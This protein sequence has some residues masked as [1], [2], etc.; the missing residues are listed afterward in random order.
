MRFVYFLFLHTL[1][2]STAATAQNARTTATASR[3]IARSYAYWNAALNAYEYDDSAR[4]FYSGSQT[5][6]GG[7]NEL[8]ACDSVH[9]FS[10]SGTTVNSTSRFYQSFDAAGNIVQL[11]HQLPDGSGGYRLYER[12]LYTY[13]AT[14]HLLSSTKDAYDVPTSSWE[15]QYRMLYTRSAAGSVT[16]ETNE[17]WN[18]AT[19]AWEPDHRYT[20]TF[21]AS[22]ALTGRSYENWVGGAWQPV[23]R[24]TYT[25][26]AAGLPETMISEGYVAA[27]SS[28]I[29]YNREL[30]TFNADGKQTERYWQYWST[31]EA[32]WKNN[33]RTLTTYSGTLPTEETRAYWYGTATTGTWEPSA[34]NT[35]THDAAG[36]QLTSTDHDWNAGTSSYDPR[37]QNKRTY[38]SYNQETE[39]VGLYWDAALGGFY[40]G[41]SSTS[42]ARKY[43]ETYTG[44]REDL[45]AAGP[46]FRVYPVP[47]VAVMNVMLEET[48]AADAVVTLLSGDGRVLQQ[49]ALQG[50]RAILLVD[51]LPAGSYVVRLSADGSVQSRV[52]TISGDAR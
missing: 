27:T 41:P 51:G 31:P 46:A 12:E 25:I 8:P 52:V 20:Y 28:W 44:L 6:A 14:G 19:N 17:D 4:Y 36:N 50:G 38:N 9:S 49:Q 42:R 1:L 22:E 26:N 2:Q 37:Y 7:A 35:F 47:A 15:P 10:W 33:V 18:A 34:K 11:V 43:Y 45:A 23:T 21:S 3:M 16:D 5:G 29:F 32:A 39:S 48:I 13:S 24:Y 40:P 30:L